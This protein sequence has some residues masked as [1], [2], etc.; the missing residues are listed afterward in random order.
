MNSGTYYGLSWNTSNLGGNEYLNFVISGAVEV[1]AY[2]F[3]ILTLDKWGRK[4]ILC[5][6]MILAGL[7]LIATVFV[8][9]GEYLIYPLIFFIYIFC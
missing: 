1:P 2:T 8:P 4:L 5:G 7:C 3:L 9:Y 6:A